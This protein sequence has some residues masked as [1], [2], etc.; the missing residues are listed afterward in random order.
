MSEVFDST[1]D[2]SNTSGVSETNENLEMFKNIYGTRIE[3]YTKEINSQFRKITYGDFTRT[4]ITLKDSGTKIT[5]SQETEKIDGLNRTVNKYSLTVG[6]DEINNLHESR[7]DMDLFEC[8]MKIVTHK[9]MH[10]LCKHLDVDYLAS[11]FSFA[12]GFEENSWWSREDKFKTPYFV[13]DPIL[14]EK[15]RGKDKFNPKDFKI[16]K[17]AFNIAADFEINSILGIRYPFLHPSDYGLPEGLNLEEYYSILYQL[18]KDN[19]NI[20]MFN[21][22]DSHQ[23]DYLQK[24]YSKSKE[25]LE[26]L[27]LNLA[28]QELCH[29]DNIESLEAFGGSFPEFRPIIDELKKNEKDKGKFSKLPGNITGMLEKLNYK[30]VG[31]WKEFRKVLNYIKKKE[32]DMK[33]SFVDKYDNWCKFNNRKDGNLLYPGKSE[34][35]GALERKIGPHSVMFVDISGSMSEVID[36]LYTLCYFLVKKMDITLVFYDTEIKYI[37][38]K[39]DN[40]VLEPFIGGGT[41]FGSAYKQYL[42]TNKK[43]QNI[44]VLTDGYDYS[45]KDYPEAKIWIVKSNSI[46]D[47]KGGNSWW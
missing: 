39:S 10:V 1:N 31:I 34:R 11:V 2:T 3:Q 30:E 38:N 40:F 18:F 37:F 42:E 35:E 4:N 45:L 25:K 43:I 9:Y 47:Y 36:P 6:F 5:L 20:N 15:T 32:K 16:N 19:E 7:P 23:S 24:F 28:A 8:F 14:S 27:I 33:L 46:V 29:L 26:N 22:E 12:V 13:Y 41:D 21:L 44:Y 17:T